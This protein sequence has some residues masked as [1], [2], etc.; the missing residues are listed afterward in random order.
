MKQATLI[1]VFFI[2]LGVCFLIKQEVGNGEEVIAS[3]NDSICR[4]DSFSVKDFVLE[5]HLQKIKYPDVVL[6]QACLESGFFTS[7]IWKEKNKRIK[8]RI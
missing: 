7:K 3:V 4:E 5:L 2:F 1:L 8:K 6:R